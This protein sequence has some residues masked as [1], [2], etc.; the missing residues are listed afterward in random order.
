MTWQPIIQRAAYA[1]FCRTGGVCDFKLARRELVQLCGEISGAPVELP[2]EGFL[3]LQA[4]VYVPE[5]ALQV[6]VDE[7]C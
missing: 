1:V 4:R 5:L 7:W 6:L 2:K 3:R